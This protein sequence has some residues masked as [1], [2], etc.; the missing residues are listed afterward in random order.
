MIRPYLEL[1]EL[2]QWCNS[3]IMRQQVVYGVAAL[4][5]IVWLDFLDLDKSIPVLFWLTW[6]TLSMVLQFVESFNF[7][8]IWSSILGSVHKQSGI[9]EGAPDDRPYKRGQGL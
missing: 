1:P 4:N 8:L 6:L 2:L 3:A 9:G 7:N 5:Y